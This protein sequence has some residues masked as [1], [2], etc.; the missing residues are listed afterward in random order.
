MAAAPDILLVGG[1]GFIGRHLAR[2]LRG[3]GHAVTVLS[4]GRLAPVP[5]ATM[6][7]ADRDDPA[8][9][10]AALGGRRFAL[11]VD[12]GAYDAPDLAWL[13]A[14]PAGSLGRV[15]MISTGQVY[16]VGEGGAPPYV[17][18]DDALPL[19]AEPAAGSADHPQWRYGAG[20]R[21]AEAALRARGEALGI[22][23]TALRLPIV[24]GED[25]RSLRLW[26]YLERML[27][28]GPIV[29]P[30]GGER[31]ARFLD[32]A[33]LAPVVARIAAGPA[34]RRFAYNLAQPDT[35]TLREF[36]DRVARAAGVETRFV[37]ASW[38]RCGA[39]GLPDGFLPYAGRW[40]SQLDPARAVAE[41]G[42]SGTPSDTYVPRIVRWTLAHRPA[43]SD[44]G[45]AHRAREVELAARLAGGGPRATREP[46]A[47]RGTGAMRARTRGFLD[48]P[49]GGG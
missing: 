45:Y 36:L 3:L 49:R 40:A 27:D 14:V 33:D 8:A 43:A 28:G 24:Q 38:E 41:L 16:L 35:P 44:E 30:D 4:R 15:L 37:A 6:L 9:V 31:P 47:A 2:G 22:A 12:F 1:S 5:G 39:A 34:P 29:L 7:P 25:D 10:A 48:R 21:R 42:F 11:A 18:D 32:V 13:A 17:E 26:A 19:R 46:P 20:K 23:T